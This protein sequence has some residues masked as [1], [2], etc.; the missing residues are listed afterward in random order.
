VIQIDAAL[1]AA[2]AAVKAGRPGEGVKP[3]EAA[4]ATEPSGPRAAMMHYYL[5]VAYARTDL[6]Q[7]ATHLRAAIA[8][9]VDQDDARFQLALVLDR[10]G[11]YVQARTEYDRFATAHPQ[12]PLAVF[13]LRRSATLA[14]LPA[15][16]PP[17]SGPEAA[18]P[19]PAAAPAPT[20]AT[21]PAGAAPAPAAAP[22]A[23]APTVA[24]AP[25]AAPP[26]A[27]PAGA[28]P[29]GLPAPGSHPIAAPVPPSTPRPVRPW[30]KPWGKPAA[31][32]AG[33]AASP[34]DPPADRAADP[35]SD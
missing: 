35:P 25:L 30:P 34:G 14:R 31:K 18:P 10:S 33:S 1:K 4:L 24:G 16:G 21:F 2:A 11:A 22:S 29:S 13:A 7:G 32:P 27:A 3:L 8:G 5:G 17:A 12:A 28:S 6:D 15:A 19:G 9:D 26:G 20:A 23:V